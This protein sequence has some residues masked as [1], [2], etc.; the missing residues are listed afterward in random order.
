[1]HFFLIQTIF[2]IFG[3]VLNV[4]LIFMVFFK[5]SSNSACCSAVIIVKA[6]VDIL[7]AAVAGLLLERILSTGDSVII[8]FTGLCFSHFSCFTGH[9]FLNSF[10]QFNLIWMV[11]SYLFR[12]CILYRKSPTPKIV[13]F[14][15]VTI[16]LPLLIHNIIWINLFT[17]NTS[18][19]APKIFS[20]PGDLVLA[21]WVIQVSSEVVLASLGV[22]GLLVLGF[23]FVVRSSLMGFLRR[24]LARLSKRSFIYNSRLLKTIHLQ[25]LI[26]IFISS[27][28]FI[29]FSMHYY[30]LDPIQVQFLPILLYTISTVI[31]PISYILFLPPDGNLCFGVSKNL[32]S[33]MNAI[34]SVTQT[35]TNNGVHDVSVF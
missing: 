19:T 5:L 34:E 17:E 32:K 7:I 6:V 20:K 30:I 12:H 4:I 18:F 21:G 31:S 35:V 9:I 27:G 11:A 22:S 1:M 24:N 13:G 29:F 8:I 3:V 26:P 23:Y 25:S 15:V 14:S 28:T 10:H 2:S 33:K 16:S